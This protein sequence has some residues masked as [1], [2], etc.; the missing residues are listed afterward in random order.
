MADCVPYSVVDRLPTRFSTNAYLQF[1]W[2][3][4]QDCYGKELQRG[5]QT[6]AL[7]YRR[8]IG[9]SNR[10]C[11]A[12]HNKSRFCYINPCP[13]VPALQWCS[14]SLSTNTCYAQITFP[15]PNN[16]SESWPNDLINSAIKILDLVLL[17]ICGSPAIGFPGFIDVSWLHR[18]L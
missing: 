15:H 6:T 17:K 16:R 3:L 8:I 7:R 10:V 13:L 4:Y 14:H 11:L 12:A 5:E 18:Q 9:K 1:S 2:L